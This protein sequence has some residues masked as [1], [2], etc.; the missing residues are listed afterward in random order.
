ML[1]TLPFACD[2]VDLLFIL[3]LEISS[4]SP[5]RIHYFNM[6]PAPAQVVPQRSTNFIVAGGAIALEQNF[7]AHNHAVQTIAALGCLLLDKCALDRVQV[8]C[9]SKAFQS[10][11]VSTNR[12]DSWDY[13]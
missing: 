3:L 6:R 11:D 9:G 7:G 8:L 1:S 4:G 13:T 5:H 10:G 2:D 12:C